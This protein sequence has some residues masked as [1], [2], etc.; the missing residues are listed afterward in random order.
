MC[1][2]FCFLAP[3][4]LLD[5]TG[6]YKGQL[7]AGIPS[8]EGHWTMVAMPGGVAKD[9]EQIRITGVPTD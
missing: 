7:V 2:A 4:L 1:S 8:G 3:L 5:C 9:G 6:T